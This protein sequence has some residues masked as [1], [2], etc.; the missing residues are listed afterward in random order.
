MQATVNGGMI[1]NLVAFDG[2]AQ[3]RSMLRTT[4]A[5]DADRA[6]RV[7]DDEMKR[8]LKSAAVN[9]I[10]D[11]FCKTLFVAA[12]TYGD[13]SIDV[14]CPACPDQGSPLVR[15]FRPWLDS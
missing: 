7:D 15:Y 1:L 14:A 9:E 6:T 5:C 4:V 2:P 12:V 3:I 8:P 10:G 11:E 13:A